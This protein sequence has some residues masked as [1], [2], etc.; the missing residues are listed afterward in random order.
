MNLNKYT[1]KKSMNYKKDKIQNKKI[2]HTKKIKKNKNH[3]L[4]NYKINHMKLYKNN[5]GTDKLF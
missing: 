1:I 5:S 2:K 3:F 4:H